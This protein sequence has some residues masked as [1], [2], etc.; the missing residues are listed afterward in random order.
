MDCLT[1]TSPHTPT[2]LRWQMYCMRGPCL[3]LRLLFMTTQTQEN[4]C[5]ISKMYSRRA[6]TSSF[7]RDIPS[8]SSS[9]ATLS[10]WRVLLVVSCSRRDLQSSCGQ[11]SPRIS[12]I[13]FKSLHR[14]LRSEMLCQHIHTFVQPH[15]SMPQATMDPLL[16][17]QPVSGSALKDEDKLA[18]LAVHLTGCSNS[19]HASKKPSRC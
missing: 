3:G 19:R 14:T 11:V 5:D 10:A 2:S 12:H 15:E 8:G 16:I 1:T 4:S 7:D 17:E 6:H 13:A 18:Y 9:S